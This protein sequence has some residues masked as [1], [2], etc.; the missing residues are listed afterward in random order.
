MKKLLTTAILASF[1]FLPLG[2]GSESPKGGAPN[3]D[4]D[5][6]FKLVAEKTPDSLKPGDTESVKLKVQRG[7]DFHKNVR[8]AAKAPDKINV[9]LDRDLIKD[10]DNADVTVKIHPEADAAPGDYKF[11]IT[12]TP[13]SGAATNLELKVTVN[14]K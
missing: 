1:A 14:K 11:T 5:D 10:G 9:T 8:L 7:K 13:D 4:S 6:T 3:K 12:G 2:C